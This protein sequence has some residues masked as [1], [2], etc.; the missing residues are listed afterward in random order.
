MTDRSR[1]RLAA[2]AACLSRG[3]G[4]YSNNVAFRQSSD[5]GVNDWRDGAHDAERPAIGVARQ[6][7]T[8]RRV[9]PRRPRLLSHA[10]V[11]VLVNALSGATSFYLLLSVVPL[12]VSS[13]GADQRGAG[14]ATGALMLATV[15]GEGAAP[16]LM[17][18][19]GYRRML[20]AGLLLMGLPALA[21]AETANVTVILA[22]SVLRGFGLA[23]C[24]VVGGALVALL[25]PPER[26]GEGLGLVGAVAGVPAL[27]A[28]PLGVWLARHA[29]YPLVF[30]TGAIAALAGL[31]AVPGLA[32]VEPKRGAAA[33]KPG[34]GQQPTGVL[35]G[36]RMPAL[37]RPSVAF[38]AT[39]MAAGVVV[40]FLPLA[41]GQRSG[42]LVA[43]ALG[44]QPGAVTLSRWWAGRYGDRHGPGSLLAPGILAAAAGIF[45]LVFIGNPAAVLAGMVLFGGGFGIAQNA[46]LALMLQRVPAS[47][48]GTVTA[49]WNLAYDSAMGLGATGFGMLA[50]NTGYRAAFA[51]TAMLVLAALVPA[52]RDRLGG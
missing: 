4:G 38:S 19:F 51:L 9:R 20:A 39:A 47:G 23:I 8:A 26:R 37:V 16:R 32:G 45:A 25:V 14:L 10:L 15:A 7:L 50:A 52:W 34:P 24:V 29:G 36:L 30:V 3:G 31:V 33:R 27:V 41:I 48:Y 49:M 44:V 12:Y 21:L 17:T 11:L 22:V 40:T 42:N 28:L 5:V 18:R 6:R 35:A 46:S 1:R 43:L 2:H 13:A